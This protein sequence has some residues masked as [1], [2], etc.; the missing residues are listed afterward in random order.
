MVK[1]RV[2]PRSRMRT[3][4]PTVKSYFCAVPR[5]M[6]TSFGVVGGR[7]CGE[8]QRRRSA[9]SG[10]RR[11]RAWAPRRSR[12]PCRRGRRIARRP[13]TE[14]SAAS[15]PGTARTVASER[16]GHRVAGGRAA[17][18][19][20]GHA[21]DLEV[22]VLVD[23]A[24]QRVERVVQRVGEH[25]GAGNERHAEHDGQRRQGEAEL[26]GQQ[27]LDGDPPHVR[28]RA[29]RMRSRTE[30]GV[31]SGEL[32]DDLAVGQE[33]DPVGV[34]RP[35]GVVGDHDDGLAEL[36]HRPAQERQHLGRGVG[37]QVPGG[38]VGEDEVGPVDQGPGAG[39]ALLLP[40]RH[41]A[42]PVASAG[43]R[44]RAAPTR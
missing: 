5:S 15:T 16:L 38:L 11:R 36:G 26:V 33:D 27:S 21:A 24:E 44:C 23:V 34:G 30:S 20:L 39:A 14:P 28:L 2:G 17:A 8:M 12:W 22:D 42:G 9:G 19:E 25:E 35:A 41:L 31:G 4:W 6:T 1:V 40:A 32:V 29:V 7:P 3:F 37:V 43:R 10:R 13:V 18:P